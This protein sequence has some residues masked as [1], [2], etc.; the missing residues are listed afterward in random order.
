MRLSLAGK[1]ENEHCAHRATAGLGLRNRTEITE[2]LA[3][4]GANG[5]QGQGDHYEDQQLLKTREKGQGESKGKIMQ[6]S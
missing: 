2:V 4:K 3:V 1:E 6:N 5:N